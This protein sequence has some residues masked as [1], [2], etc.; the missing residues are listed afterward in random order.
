VKQFNLAI[1][2]VLLPGALPLE[3]T[4]VQSSYHC[5][6]V[7]VAP[8]SVKLGAMVNNSFIMAFPERQNVTLTNGVT[9]DIT[10][11]NVTYKATSQLPGGLL[12][13]GLK[14]NSYYIHA[15]VNEPMVTFEKQFLGFSENEVIVGLIVTTANLRASDAVLGSPTTQYDTTDQG[16]GL[17]L[18][19]V[20]KDSVGFQPA[21]S[22]NSFTN[23]VGFSETVTPTS[24]TDF[25]V[26]TQVIP[27]TPASKTPMEAGFAISGLAGLALLGLKPWRRS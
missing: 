21:S 4:V 3:A 6:Y 27:T 8:P 5:G 15:N 24:V 16:I 22:T 10:T 26:V 20:G 18:F 13:A 12:L 14:V 11:P 17:H 19:P 2:L 25:R 23:L 1:I 7:G 9:V